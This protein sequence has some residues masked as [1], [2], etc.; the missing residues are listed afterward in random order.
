[1]MSPSTVHHHRVHR[2]LVVGH[3]VLV[4]ASLFWG[5][6]FAY[7]GWWHIAVSDVVMVLIGLLGLRWLQQGGLLRSAV[8]LLAASVL[9][10]SLQSLYLDVPS[11]A[12]PRSVHLYLLPLMAFS[13]VVFRDEK[14]S[15]RYGTAA[16]CLILF[17]VFAS[18]PH[19]L[20]DQFV[21]PD[22]VRVYGTWITATIATA[23]LA[24]LLHILQSDTLPMS[25]L[26][27][28][29]RRAVAERQMVLHFQPQVDASGQ[30]LGA[31]A[32]VRWQHPVAGIIAPGDFIPL[33]ERTGLIVP[34]GE[35]VLEKA[36]QQLALWAL[37]PS[38][39][40]LTLSVNV[41]AAQVNQEHFVQQVLAMV[42]SNA[43][44]PG[45]LRLELTE[46]ML[47]NDMDMVIQK[48]TALKAHGI[49]FSI[50]DFGTGFSSLNYLKH[51]PLDEIKIDK[52]F[53][54]D[55]VVDESDRAI[56]KSL[57]ALGNQLGLE[58]IAEGV[59]T[60]VQ[61]QTLLDCG[62]RVFQGHWF[63]RPEPLERFE[64]Y[65]DAAKLRQGAGVSVTAEL[66]ANIR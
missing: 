52:S 61:W 32:L 51:L 11:A 29:L 39:A 42:Q 63:A 64:A 38:F 37:Q 50:D 12:A 58:V 13:L 56:V 49:G 15:L 28:E 23:T 47:V 60:Q 10:L 24:V 43:I 25:V 14:P 53:V 22:H 34:I 31:E 57:L 46:S 19:G 16:L 20:S 33:A 3:S 66:Q 18:W 55:V 30:V 17:V 26:E 8:L 5:I 7:M 6:H 44:S 54:D 36:G 21:L 2:M 40:D 9:I 45:R 59:E 4:L 41:S 1:M 65:V 35:Q 27:Q 48:M 62:C